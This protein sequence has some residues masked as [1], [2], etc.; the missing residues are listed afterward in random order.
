MRTTLLIGLAL[1]SLQAPL[2]AEGTYLT[3]HV[4]PGETQASLAD[5]YGLSMPELEKANPGADF[6]Q[7][8]EGQELNIPPGTGW[9]RHKV[10]PG[11]TF[12][13]I[14]K[15]YDVPVDEIKQVNQR[16]DDRLLVGESLLVPRHT[17]QALPATGWIE[18]TLADGRKAWAPVSS[19][20]APA[21]RPLSPAE[22]VALARKLTG[23]PYLWGGVTPNGVDCSGFV[24]EVFRL[25]GYDLRRTADLQFEDCQEVRREEMQTG[26][27]VF[28]STYEPGPSHVGICTEPGKFLHASSSRGV[29][30]SSLEED[31]Y[32]RRFLG[33]RRLPQWMAP[34]PTARQPLPPPDTS[35]QA[36]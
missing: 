24:Q 15:L 6:T 4:Q 1:L 32:A 11:Q 31:Y 28:F 25:G 7:L 12:W 18:V 36:P 3:H 20:L 13:A 9:P 26:D 19:L 5:R 33:V 10:E 23:V 8:R 35:S 17:L 14:S 16:S 2:R 30:E 27:L 22:L 21:P 29:T 34:P